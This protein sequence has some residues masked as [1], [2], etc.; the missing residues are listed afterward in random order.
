MGKLMQQDIILC[1]KQERDA[2]NYKMDLL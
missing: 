2:L 1:S